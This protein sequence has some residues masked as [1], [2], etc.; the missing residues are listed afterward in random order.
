MIVG[1]DY[2]GIGRQ[3]ATVSGVWLACLVRLS[4]WLE[5][6]RIE[7]DEAADYRGRDKTDRANTATN[8]EMART[9]VEETQN[10]TRSR[11]DELRL[12]PMMR[13]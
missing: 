12:F 10:T 7:A 6:A 3:R 8:F 11:N 9:R 1:R 13:H 4:V 5:C 2:A